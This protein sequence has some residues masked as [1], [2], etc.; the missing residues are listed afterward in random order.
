MTSLKRYKVIELSII[1][2]TYGRANKIKIAIDSAI[3]D[4]DFEVIVVDDNGI[5]SK[6]QIETQKALEGYIKAGLIKYLPL[7]DNSGASLA[8][9][10]G[11]EEASGRY[12]TFLDDDDYF[13][14]G[15]LIAKLNYFKKERPD[16]DICGSDMKVKEKNVFIETGDEK[17]IGENAK[18]FLLHG[19]SYTSM[20]MIK[21]S[22]IQ[23][24]GG[25]LITPYLQD[26]TL[27]LNAYINDLKVC[28]Y[29]RA[30]FVHTIH[31]GGTITN[32]TRPIRG[33]ELRCELERKLSGKL[34]LDKK[35]VRD[36]YYRWNTIEFYRRWLESGRSL[37]L[38]KF[39][40]T[41][42]FFYSNSKIDYVDSFKL[43]IKFLIKY[44]YYSK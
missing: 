32:G 26:H 21:K 4:C 19:S 6:Q 29:N 15:E 41:K 42:I 44:Q 20:I 17:F 33:V 11:I 13:L 36:L 5:G 31:E 2:P 39:L 8:R 35:D 25:F 18:K 40:L 34:V 10:V 1:I 9:N 12:I 38:L 28:V 7:K 23:K 37:S 14:P 24:I 22:S 3:I 16:F 30:T 27:M 43:L